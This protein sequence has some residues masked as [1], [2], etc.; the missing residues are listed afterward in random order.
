MVL[1]H[2]IKVFNRKGLPFVFGV[3]FLTADLPSPFLTLV[4]GLWRLD[5]IAGGRF[6]GV[7][8]ILGELRNQLRKPGHLSSQFGDQCLQVGMW[9]LGG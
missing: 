3:P 9:L 5:D 7:R 8:G 1:P 2:I 6:G 4:L